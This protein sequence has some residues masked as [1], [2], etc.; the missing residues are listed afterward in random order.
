MLQRA[1]I[2]AFVV[3]AL[4]GA[5]GVPSGKVEV[6]FR[7]GT[8][9]AVARSP[10]DGSL[11]LDLQGT[12]WSLA[13]DGGRAEPL[14]DGLGDDRLPD[15][16]RDGTRIV[17]QSFRAGSWDIWSMA[18]DGSE[19]TQLTSSEF[20]DREPVLSPDG[21]RLAFSSD[22]SGNY[23]VWLLDIASRGVE[24][25]TRHEANDYMPAWSPDGRSIVFVSERGA[26]EASEL[27][28]IDL[29]EGREESRVASVNG[30]LAS[31]S[32]SPDGRRIAVRLLERDAMGIKGSR[33]DQGRASKLVVI[34]ID[35]ADGELA[36]LGSMDDVF[37]FRPQWLSDEELMFTADGRIWKLGLS[38]DSF[39]SSVPF[40]IQVTLDRPDYRR[41]ATPLPVAGALQQA[42]GIVRPVVSP[43]ESM[44]AFAALGDLWILPVEGGEPFPLTRD[45]YL[46][47]DPFWSP[48]GD[49]LVF[50]SDRRGSV[51]LWI[52][53]IDSP[54]RT[55]ER[56]LTGMLGA[57]FGAAWSPDGKRVAFL[58]QQ[59]RLHVI[60]VEGG[61]PT[62]LYTPRRWASLPSWSSDSEHIALAVHE[63][64][65]TRFREG[66]NRIL[67]V[68]AESGKARLLDEPGRSFGTRDG[69][70][71]VWS[72]DGRHLAFAM[73]GGLWVLPV[74]PDG[75]PDGRLR[76]VGDEAAD[77]PAWSPDSAK[78]YYVAADG[79]KRVPVEAG[80]A[81]TL[82]LGLAYQVGAAGGRMVI[83]DVR[84]I[85]G[86]DEPPRDHMDI[87]LDGNRIEKIVP[88]AETVGE[89]VPVLEGAGKTVIPGLI[90][91]HT[92]L[93]LPAWGS[94]HGKAWLAF[95]VTSIR[96]P[97]SAT[98]RII[99]E[100]E[101]IL[102][103]RRIGPRVFATGFSADGDR[104]YYTGSLS[105]RD[106]KGLASELAR[107]FALDYDLV[108]TY[109][110]L[111]DALQKR[112]IEKA[113][114]RGVFVTSHELYPAVAYGIDGIE[115][116]KGTS[117]RGFS[118]KIT[119]M[120][121]SYDD[122]VQ[123]ISRSGVY[124]TPT[125]LISGGFNLVLARE[126]N[127]LDD[128]RAKTLFPFWVVD[129][130]RRPAPGDAASRQAL[131]RPVFASVR[132]ISEEGGRILAGTDSPIVPY[133]LSLI[134]E[135]EQ[136]SEAGLG[137]LKAIRSATSVAAQALGA[138]RDLGTVEV[139]KIA[140]LVVLAGDPTEDIRNLRR[141]E[142]V[143]VNG[144]LLS[145]EK[146]LR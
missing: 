32:F 48:D 30:A 45:E 144:R 15:I 93:S 28:R 126:P 100:R 131:M 52:K 11:I 44:I 132:A 60:D 109:V 16:A 61:E 23:D 39:A 116:V 108:K 91:M 111:T 145:V 86:T 125:L 59:N 105:I 31:P 102:A 121:E 101:A 94:R 47:T 74:T 129:N 71:P 49:S 72:A 78:I 56:Q 143:I 146:L 134:L 118:P 122:V 112:V 58:D 88:T 25:L 67:I 95:G 85:D 87:W 3:L 75:S 17:F 65:S 127:L 136:L 139:G 135:V 80:E 1:L 9:F 82:E 89:E 92:H 115:H 43:D 21:A 33:F 35:E 27:Y 40:E 106:E 69:D 113:H 83:R 96:S 81:E 104:I 4:G 14:T 90:D 84:L 130:A 12:L 124:Y 6:R 110:R 50:S 55:G 97:Q 119:E 133:G 142:S 38:E 141:T 64:F 5:Q 34:P 24:Q 120:G 114:E 10:A 79:L 2:V 63:P 137:P 51:D 57:E 140:D 62:L 138:A 29:G 20:D 128:P 76:Q 8:N 103:G 54:P 37:P 13:S 117:R 42:R 46:D 123:L 107:A 53:A 70:G 7:E 22:R 68:S 36:R 77:F 41:R 66:H 19:L 73:D 99:E 98:Y 18:P 26:G